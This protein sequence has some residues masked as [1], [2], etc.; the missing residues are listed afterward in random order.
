MTVLMA[1]PWII[2]AAVRTD[3]SLKKAADRNTG[4]IQVNGGKWNLSS[5]RRYRR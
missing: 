5:L 2:A 4:C 1:S 3:Q